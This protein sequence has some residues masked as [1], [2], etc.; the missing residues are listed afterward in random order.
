MRRILDNKW[1]Q[2][3]VG[4]AYIAWAAALHMRPDVGTLRNYIENTTIFNEYSIAALFLLLGGPMLFR[5]HSIMLWKYGVLILPFLTACGYLFLYMVGNPTTSML[6]GFGMLIFG[7][8]VFY[9]L[10]R[11]AR[12]VRRG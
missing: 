6:T 4:A 2:R 1:D 8:Y 12:M 3:F 5:A 11:C 7:A 10:V 9:N